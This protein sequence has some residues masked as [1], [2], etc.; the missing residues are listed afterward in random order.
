MRL[1]FSSQLITDNMRYFTSLLYQ[2]WNSAQDDVALSPM[3]QYYSMSKEE[4]EIGAHS[5]YRATVRLGHEVSRN[6]I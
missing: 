2:C 3:K 1:G 6:G 5:T 4:V